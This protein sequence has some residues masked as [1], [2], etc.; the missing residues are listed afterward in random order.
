[1]VIE[2][3]YAAHSAFA[4]LGSARFLEIARMAGREIVHRPFD[5]DRAIETVGA[6]PFRERSKAHVAYFFG[7][8]IQ[9]WSCLLYTSD[10]A[11]DYFW[12]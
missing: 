6:G 11:D 7:R 1:M 3:F 12:V 8:E 10:A 9:R 4:Y 2:Y 5:L